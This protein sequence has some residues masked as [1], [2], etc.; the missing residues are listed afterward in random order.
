MNLIVGVII[1]LVV[2]AL[3]MSGKLRTLL[4][5]FLSLFVEDLSKTP[6][7]A[8]AVYT[9]AI[10]EAQDEYNEA[11]TLYRRI[12]GQLREAQAKKEEAENLSKDL[13]EKAKILASKNRDEEALEVILAKEE[14]DGDVEIWTR[15]AKELTKTCADAKEM[16]TNRE[17][18]LRKLMK[19]KKQVVT[20]LRMNK[21]MSEIYDSMDELKNKKTTDKLISGIK[22]KVVDGKNEVAGAK[23][24]HENRSTTKMQRIDEVT[25]KSNATAYLEKLKSEGK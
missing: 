13:D 7:G 18:M 4:S 19:D 20:Q 3:I 8:E 6:E 10:E 22:E 12:A 25:K 14:A 5:G 2:L 24:I 16:H 11:D 1:F 15:T 17:Q 9:K 23:V 21:Q